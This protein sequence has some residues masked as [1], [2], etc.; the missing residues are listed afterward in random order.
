MNIVR[1]D[2]KSKIYKFQL[3]LDPKGP[4]RWPDKRVEENRRAIDEMT[5]SIEHSKNIYGRSI[6]ERLRAKNVRKEEGRA[7]GQKVL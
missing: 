1:W 3:S 2:V 7:L 4:S 6:P 5:R